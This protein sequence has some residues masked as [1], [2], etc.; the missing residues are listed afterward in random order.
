MKRLL[1]HKKV[2]RRLSERIEKRSESEFHRTKRIGG[3]LH[4]IVPIGDQTGKILY[5]AI[6]PLMVE[7]RPRDIMQIIVGA[8]LFAIPVS[9]TEEAWN[10]GATLPLT[11]VLILLGISLIFVAMF[12]Y[13]NFY[14]FSFRG[15]V[16]NYI[17]R[18]I[19]T[20]FLSALVVT[21]LLTIIEK[22]PWGV[23]NLLA[24]KRIII[25]SFPASMSATLSDTIK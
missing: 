18:V 6:K 16:F 2:S 13:F 5:F 22:C 12:I 14:R 23:N 25:I 3:Y 20:Y 8:A 1:P 15:N 9:F 17:K 4:R 24:I 19:A 21:I 11:N 7:L 10:L